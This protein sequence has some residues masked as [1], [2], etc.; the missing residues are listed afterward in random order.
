MKSAVTCCE[1]AV[2]AAIYDRGSILAGL[3]W[4]ADAISSDCH[5]CRRRRW[6]AVA[7]VLVA[8]QRAAAAAATSAARLRGGDGPVP[9]IAALT[10]RADVPV[11]LDG[12]GTDARAQ[13]RHGAS[14]GRRQADQRQLQRRP[15]R[16]AR[17]RAGA[18]RSD[19]LPGATRSG[20]REEGAGRGDARQRAHRSRALRAACRDQL[21]RAPADSTRR[22]RRSR[23]SRRR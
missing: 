4:R 11:Y 6:A 8:D 7:A 20:G 22:R 19:H 2:C 10:K 17:L 14:A 21:G 16:Q 9:V 15:G 18:D 1:S 23:S 12:V 13:H 5:R 3:G